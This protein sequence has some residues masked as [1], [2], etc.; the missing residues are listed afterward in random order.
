MVY[1]PQDWDGFAARHTSIHM[2]QQFPKRY[3][4]HNLSTS[5]NFSYFLLGSAWCSRIQKTWG[6]WPCLETCSRSRSLFKSCVPHG[7]RHS[8]WSCGKG[9]SV[10]R[11]K[12]LGDGNFTMAISIPS[13]YNCL[14]TLTTTVE[15]ICTIS[16][17]LL[18]IRSI[19][20]QG[21]SAFQLW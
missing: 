9:K 19:R 20:I 11:R 10:R 15:L 21:C 3:S 5:I 16:V 6:I 18:S 7:R 2:R 1:A 4:N 14:L 17:V 8:C 13:M 12:L